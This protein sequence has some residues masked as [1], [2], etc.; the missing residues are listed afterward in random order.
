MHALVPCENQMDPRL[1]LPAKPTRWRVIPLRHVDDWRTIAFLVLLCLCFFIQWTG[2]FR[3]W[4]LLSVTFILSFVACVAK[5]NHIHCRTFS[6]RTWNRAWEFVLGIC[7][8]QSTAAIIPVHNERHHARN[9]SD[10]DFVRSTIVNFRRNWLNLAAFP[11][12]V[13]WLVHRNKSEDVAGWRERK[14][15]LWRHLQQER[16]AVIIFIVVLLTINWKATLLYV[17][18]PW[19]FGQWGI[20]T[21]NLLQHQDCDHDSEFNHSRNLTGRFVNWLFLNNGYH[22]AHHLRPTLHWSRLPE[23]HRTSVEPFMRRELN[24]HSFFACLW[25]QFFRGGRIRE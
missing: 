1:S 17:A 20:V 16:A 13:V 18:L 25:K 23:F 12:R 21:I 10:E 15:R 2:V 4:A 5:H 3:S 22:T 11:F 14:P 8:G 24:H 19:A 9:H 6:N 7:T